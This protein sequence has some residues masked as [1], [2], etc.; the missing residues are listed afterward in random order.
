[1]LGMTAQW[2]CLPCVASQ[3]H[4]EAQKREEQNAMQ[5]QSM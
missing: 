3:R 4:Q 2:L 5:Q 1:M